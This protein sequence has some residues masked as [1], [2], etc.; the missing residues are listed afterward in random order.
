MTRLRRIS[1]R[2]TVAIILPMRLHRVRFMTTP[3]HLP[4]CFMELMDRGEKEYGYD[5]LT[6]GTWLNDTPR[7][8]AMF[9]EEWINNLS[10]S[11]DGFGWHFVVTARGTFNETRKPANMSART[12]RSNTNSEVPIAH[13]R[14]CAN[15]W[16]CCW[17]TRQVDLKKGNVAFYAVRLPA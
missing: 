1:L 6:T 13:S 7:W 14:R 10:G 8:L 17:E 12:W 9:P 15:I 3:L 2:I 4:V 16:R 11:D 5:T